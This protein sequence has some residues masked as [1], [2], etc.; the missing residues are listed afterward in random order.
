MLGIIFSGGSTISSLNKRDKVKRFEYPGFL[1]STD[2]SLVET[3]PPTSPGTTLTFL[4]ASAI[5]K[6]LEDFNEKISGKSCRYL[7][8][9]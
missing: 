8:L 9:L 4:T 7:Y 5:K 6:Q 2:C 3:T 1:F